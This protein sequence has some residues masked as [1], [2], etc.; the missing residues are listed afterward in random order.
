MATVAMGLGQFQRFSPIT[1][2]GLH[3]NKTWGVAVGGS[4]G[5]WACLCV[6]KS[7]KT[8]SL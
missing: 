3:T 8:V 7:T 2:V 4:V 5:R 1:W 6:K